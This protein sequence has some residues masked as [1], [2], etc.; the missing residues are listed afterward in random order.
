MNCP[1][2]SVIIS[3]K[4]EEK[5]IGNILES[6]KKQ[7]YKNIEIIVID[8]NSSDKTKEVARQYTN[9]VFD[10]GPERSSQRK[11]GAKM[12]KGEYLFFLDADMILGERV[13]EESLRIFLKEKGVIGIIIPEISIGSGFWAKCKALEK[14]FYIGVDWLEAARFFPKWTFEKVGGYDE[15]LISG[16][17]WDLS[18]RV[19][20]LGKIS[21]IEEFIEHNE[22]KISLSKTVRKKFYYSKH[23][24]KYAKKPGNKNQA[25]SQFNIFAR[26]KLFFLKPGKLFHDPLLGLGML[27]M[28]TCEFLFSGFG[29]LMGKIY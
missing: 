26:Y 20:K 4:N 25:A 9:L 10:K 23:L 14:S 1:L 5:N 15:N 18:Q 27:F 22:G 29:Y 8:N 7:S 24:A 11:F 19:A 21:R 17:D 2:V 28:K 3:T 12:A 16:E 6:L 13:I